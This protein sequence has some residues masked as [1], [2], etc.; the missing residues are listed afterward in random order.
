[1]ISRTAAV[2]TVLFALAAAVPLRA[3]LVVP[4]KG[5]TLP[6][7]EVATIK[8]SRSDLGRSFR[9]Q[10]WWNDNSYR[11]ENLTLRDF[12]RFAFHLGSAA[13]LTGGPDRLLDARFDISAKIG[14]DDYAAMQKL[15]S[16]QRERT[17][18]LMMQALLADRF[19]LKV[20]VETRTLP[21][22]N[23]IVDKG[24]AKLQPFT[25]EPAPADTA[26][27]PAT[28]HPPTPSAAASKQPPAKPSPGFRATMS[29]NQATMT[30]TGE[31]LSQPLRM[32]GH[33]PELDGRLVIDKTGLTGLYSFTLN[34]SPQRLN[35]PADPGATG[36]SLFAALKEQL[37]LRLEPSKAPVPIVVIDAITALTPN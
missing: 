14:D 35:A 30:V 15:P 17:I 23:L 24:G 5:E 11:T 20:H 27:E 19:G 3:Q 8:P 7:F 21:V 25:P 12:I 32:I 34:W 18:D 22:F 28:T 1:M 13:Q 16:D 2:L 29:R 4:D 33:Q 26:G 6:T 10:T 9:V 37:G 31:P 36:P